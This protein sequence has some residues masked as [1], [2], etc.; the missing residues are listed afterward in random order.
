MLPSVRSNPKPDT[1]NPIGI[2]LKAW[3]EPDLDVVV[4]IGDCL[5]WVAH[6]SFS[7]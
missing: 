5:G 6:R 1:L 2:V 4:A 3:E 7:F